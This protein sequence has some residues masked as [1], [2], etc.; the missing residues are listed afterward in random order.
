[1][2]KTEDSFPLPPDEEDERPTQGY[3]LNE[4]KKDVKIEPEQPNPEDSYVFIPSKSY[5]HPPIMGQMPT[6]QGIALINDAANYL[7]GNTDTASQE[8]LQNMLKAVRNL[9]T[10]KPAS[11]ASSS[12]PA[13]PAWPAYL[14][15]FEDAPPADAAM[16]DAAEDLPAKIAEANKVDLEEDETDYGFGD[17]GKTTN[18]KFNHE[19]DVRRSVQGYS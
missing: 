9:K 2:A 8:M 1:M 5:A 14:A 17:K 11:S 6:D 18:T 7:A 16:E 12:R 3:Q 13:Q 19:L 10:S 4:N 15:N